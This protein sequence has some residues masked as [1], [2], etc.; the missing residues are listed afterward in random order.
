MSS[1]AREREQV[2]G[3][4][5]RP[6]GVFQDSRVRGPTLPPRPPPPVS[7]SVSPAGP[8]AAEPPLCAAWLDRSPAPLPQRA[9]YRQWGWGWGWVLVAVF[10]RYLGSPSSPSRGESPHFPLPHPT[11][12]WSFS[13]LAMAS[14]LSC[15]TCSKEGSARVSPSAP[16]AWDSGFCW[17]VMDEEAVTWGLSEGEASPWVLLPCPCPASRYFHSVLPPFASRGCCSHIL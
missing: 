9:S 11:P 2:R 3:N 1:W 14:S 13:H 8:P 5:W 12:T 16:A 7:A 4:P 6:R 15:S 10:W 17:R